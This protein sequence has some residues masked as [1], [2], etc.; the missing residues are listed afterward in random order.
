MGFGYY[1]TVSHLNKN[2]LTELVY[3][4]LVYGY[5]L[6]KNMVRNK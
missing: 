6:A 4:V 3:E 5:L 1:Q 2:E